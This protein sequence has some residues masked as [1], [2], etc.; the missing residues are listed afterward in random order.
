M[1][2]FLHSNKQERILF[3]VAF[4][5]DTTLLASSMRSEAEVDKIT[6]KSNSN[7]ALSNESL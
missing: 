4:L 7:E 6:L 3:D 1:V 2:E 5:L